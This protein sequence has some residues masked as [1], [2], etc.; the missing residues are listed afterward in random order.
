MQYKIKQHS[1]TDWTLLPIHMT[2]VC[3]S[4]P[5]SHIRIFR[6][7]KSQLRI[8]YQCYLNLDIR[9]LIYIACTCCMHPQ[10]CVCWLTSSC[11]YV[12]SWSWVTFSM[13]ASAW[14]REAIYRWQRV[15]AIYTVVQK[16]TRQLRRALASCLLTNSLLKIIKIDWT[17]S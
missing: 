1:G 15:K 3:K 6:Y 7:F 17:G 2:R 4:D 16:K 11:A 14:R 12:Q 13:Q 8:F 5:L 9:I 10:V